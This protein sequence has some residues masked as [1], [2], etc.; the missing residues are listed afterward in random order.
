MVVHYRQ[1]MGSL[2]KKVI[3]VKTFCLAYFLII[4]FSST[5]YSKATYPESINTIILG[6]LP[7][8][9]VG[10]QIFL[11]NCSSC[12][13][14]DKKFIGPPLN[15]AIRK[16]NERWLIRFTKNGY[17]MVLNGDKK[18]VQI[19]NEYNKIIHPK[20][21][22]LNNDELKSIFDYVKLAR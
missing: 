18:A 15:E 12:H 5:T 9:S 8:T 22:H 14:I 20:F 2:F 10:K 16:H 3:H 17:Q 21:N 4:L 7:D 13:M 19:Y 11:K 6:N 1:K